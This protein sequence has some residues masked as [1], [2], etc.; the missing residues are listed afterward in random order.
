MVIAFDKG[1]NSPAAMVLL[2]KRGYPPLLVNVSAQL[3]IFLISGTQEQ[4]K[5][6]P[7]IQKNAERYIK[8]RWSSPIFAVLRQLTAI[9]DKE[10]GV[11]DQGWPVCLYL[12]IAMS[13]LSYL[14][15]PSLP[16]SPSAFTSSTTSS[17]SSTFLASPTSLFWPFYIVVRR[18]DSC[19]VFCCSYIYCIFYL[20][21]DIWYNLCRRKPLLQAQ[22]LFL[23]PCP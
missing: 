17:A 16:S 18:C 9:N 6:C 3:L 21:W 19:H 11:T 22:R 12:L 10:S 4:F 15:L 8:S 1:S 20:S 2:K 7:N 14:S 23:V 13:I 5:T